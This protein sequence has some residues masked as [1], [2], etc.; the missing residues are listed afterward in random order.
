MLSGVLR[1]LRTGWPLAGVFLTFVVGLV[2]GGFGTGVVTGMLGALAFGLAYLIQ[3]SIRRR[4]WMLPPARP[5][6][7]PQQAQFDARFMRVIAIGD[8]VIAAAF[9]VVAFSHPRLWFRASH[10]WTAVLLLSAALAITG[11]PHLWAAAERRATQRSLR[12]AWTLAGACG[13]AFGIAAAAIATVNAQS[14]WVGGAPW[15]VALAALAFL[16]L[17]GALGDLVR[18][19]R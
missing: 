19:R 1:W 12:W 18:A 2:A 17:L 4:S 8:L 5:R 10:G 9:I 14:H 11:A 15:T 3:S 7:P 6:T 16:W 13:V